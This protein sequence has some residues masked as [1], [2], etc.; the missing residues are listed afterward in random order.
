M[1]EIFKQ[2]AQVRIVPIASMEDA[3]SAPALADALLAG[4][5]PIAEVTF[6]TE[7]AEK[8]ICA[9]SARGDLLCWLARGR[10]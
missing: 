1:Q 10:C 7:A 9:L 8:A 5:L 6:R 2:I 4:G 3:Q